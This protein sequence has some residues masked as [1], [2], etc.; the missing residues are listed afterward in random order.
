[1]KNQWQGTRYDFTLPP[2]QIPGLKPDDPLRQPVM[3]FG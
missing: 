1:M 2:S 3:A